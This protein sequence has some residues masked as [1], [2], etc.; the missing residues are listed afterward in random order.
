MVRFLSGSLS[1]PLPTKPAASTL[2]LALV[3]L[4]LALGLVTAGCSN[5]SASNTPPLD[6]YALSGG[7][8]TGFTPMQGEGPDLVAQDRARRSAQ[9]QPHGK[10][11]LGDAVWA[12]LI[13]RG[14]AAA[15][16]T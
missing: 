12:A 10:R 8:I 13:R 11:G 16:G 14:P 6:A 2:L 4:L 15:S 1:T 9:H 5:P 7:K 3:P